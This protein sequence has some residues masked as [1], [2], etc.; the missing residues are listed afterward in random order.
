MKFAA[1]GRSEI[2]YNTILNLL[3]KGHKLTC[4]ITS[5]E[6]P[7][8]TKCIN[9][10]H[11]LSKKINVPFLVSS[12]IFNYKNILTKTNS[13]IGISV[14]YT[15]IVPQSVIDLFPY[16]ILNAHGGDLPRYRGNACQAWAILNGEKRVALCVHKMKGGELD[17]GDI[18][19][20]DYINID[21]NTKVSIVLKWVIDVC[22][23]L[24]GKAVE[25][26]ALDPNY[27]LEKQSQDPEDALRCYPRNAEDGRIFWHDQ[28]NYILRLIN[29]C[30]KPYP[31]AY[32]YL[33]DRKLIIWDASIV[34]DQEKFCAYPGQ[35]TAI[36][37][38]FVDVAC[39]QG[40]L[41]ITDVEFNGEV[42]VASEIIKSIR[43]R[44]T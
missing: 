36:G 27:I 31:G 33:D 42:L 12:K 10:F 39:G 38:R 7:E 9:D 22:P 25:R 13:D 34:K 18:I 24:I 44:L 26:L 28:S 15:G 40:K 35:I 20:R 37:K 5:K 2:L 1:I 4:I 23:Y 8:Y 30:N 32:C 11:D 3:E 21:D 14:N 19:T 29:A 17:S 6:A 16:G 43:K 41:R